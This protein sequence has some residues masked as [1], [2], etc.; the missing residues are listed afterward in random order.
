MRI[1]ADLEAEV[2]LAS[3]IFDTFA[4]YKKPTKL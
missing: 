1:G 4:A 2:I 3:V